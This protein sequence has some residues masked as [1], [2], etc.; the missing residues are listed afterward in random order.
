MC[1][2]AGNKRDASSVGEKHGMYVISCTDANNTAKTENDG[3]YYLKEGDKITFLEIGNNSSNMGE[4]GIKIGETKKDINDNSGN[5]MGFDSLEKISDKIISRTYSVQKN[6]NGE[7]KPDCNPSCLEFSKTYIADTTVPVVTWESVDGVGEDE[8]KIG[9]VKKGKFKDITHGGTGGIGEAAV[10]KT[11]GEYAPADSAI[12]K[13]GTQTAILYLKK[14]Q[15]KANYKVEDDNFNDVKVGYIFGENDIDGAWN[16]EFDGEK[17]QNGFAQFPQVDLA[18]VKDK[19]K[20]KMFIVNSALTA[21]DKAGNEGKT[22]TFA[23]DFQVIVDWLRPEV[24]ITAKDIV[25]NVT[26]KDI[27]TFEIKAKD[28]SYDVG[29]FVGRVAGSG[30]TEIIKQE[31]VIVENGTIL[32]YECTN[33]NNETS[34]ANLQVLASGSG[35]VKVYVKEGAIKDN[36]DNPSF[37]SDVATVTVDKDPPVIHDVTGVPT[38]WVDKAIISVVASDSG[39]GGLEYSFNDNGYSSTSTYE[40]TANGE[41][42]IKV[43]DS[44]G[45]ESAE[46]VVK[47]EKIDTKNPIISSIDKNPATE[48]TNQDVTVTINATDDESG[49]A[50]Y[51]FD[52]GNSWQTSASKTYSES[53]TIIGSYIRVKDRAGK[54]TSYG[55]NVEIKIDKIKPRISTSINPSADTEE[56]VILTI[57]ASD[58]TNGSGIASVTVNDESVTA[59]NNVYQKTI[60][61]NG[62][63]TIIARDHA[64]NETTK[65]QTINNI[66]KFDPV[67]T[68]EN[69]G[70]TYVRPTD[71]GKTK[72]K[73]AI[74]VR[75][76]NDV[77][78]QYAL[79]TSQETPTNGW[80]DS[81]QANRIQL[82]SEIAS[83]GNYYLHA[84]V[85]KNNMTRTATSQIFKVV[86]S[87]IDLSANTIETVQSVIVTATYGEGLTENRKFGVGNNMSSNTNT[88]TLTENGKVHAEA[89]DVA[90]N[91][92][93]ADL[94]VNNIVPIAQPKIEQGADKYIKNVIT[95]GDKNYIIVNP[96]TTAEQLKTNVI[97]DYEKTVEATVENGQLKTG[98]ILKIGTV[99]SEYIIVVKGDAD[100]DGKV[101]FKD[102]VKINSIRLE[103]LAI[104]NVPYEVQIA[105]DVDGNGKIEFGDI[106]KINSYRLGKTNTL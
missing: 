26:N 39:V 51:S 4:H 37:A 23:E 29:K 58:E 14:G 40:V 52:N 104:A 78:I 62:D 28:Q 92:V 3:K 53:T 49:V 89:T 11:S 105:S 38:D 16:G 74:D 42:K 102:I 54:V 25:N 13:N 35:P 50:M 6:D 45:N 71:G 99:N 36:C 30:V 69:D 80:S 17:K 84:K 81:V 34:T 5:A 19:N 95:N 10:D 93:Y 15:F 106:V 101:D 8:S 103:K 94:E 1:D 31:D 66:K 73:T 27:L 43:R 72:I 86:N 85:T 96:T 18:T 67:I 48:W 20:D 79:T 41:V 46:K 61:S 44:L 22:K 2:I 32:S 60:T 90:G 70:N 91:K 12:T 33:S 100:C 76:E 64:G 83:V 97:T 7:I 47:I 9:W 56:K 88:I 82:N 77:S 57:T 21:T 75:G 55:R 63:Y 87:V 65:V 24:K 98:S 59:N 68:I